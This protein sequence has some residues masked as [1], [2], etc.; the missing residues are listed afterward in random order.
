M[1][2]VIPE[3]GFNGKWQLGVCCGD[4][5]SEQEAGAHGKRAGAGVENR[6]PGC[7][8]RRSTLS[9]HAVLTQP[10]DSGELEQPEARESLAGGVLTGG[11]AA[12]Q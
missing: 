9:H 1:P 11:T 4:R 2:F 8:G 10:P 3:R 5:T 12:E 6:L 7:G